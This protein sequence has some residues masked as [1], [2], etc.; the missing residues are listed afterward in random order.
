MG[1]F[2]FL[3]PAQTEVTAKAEALQKKMEEALQKKMD[4][5]VA[6]LSG[7]QTATIKKKPARNKKK[8]KTTAPKP[9]LSVEGISQ[10]II[11]QRDSLI[12]NGFKHYEFI[13][14]KSCCEVCAKLN[15]KHFHI[16]KMVIGVNAPPMHDGCKCSIAAWVDS[17]DYEA[18]LDSIDNG[19]TTKQWQTNKKQKR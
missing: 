8:R 3:T 5:V 17:D 4:D 1:I 9:D 14:N 2:D 13:A 18:W 12:R 15:G 19:G 16:S 11:K 7:N 6:K 10:Q